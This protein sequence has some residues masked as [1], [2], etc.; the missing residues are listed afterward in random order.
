MRNNLNESLDNKYLWNIKL[1]VKTTK[2]QG[3]G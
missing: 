3:S 1:E 2:N